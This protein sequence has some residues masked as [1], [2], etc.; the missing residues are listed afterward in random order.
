ML[1]PRKFDEEEQLINDSML[2]EI[3]YAISLIED[4]FYKL[5]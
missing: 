1:E 2:R 5:E 3:L 4:S